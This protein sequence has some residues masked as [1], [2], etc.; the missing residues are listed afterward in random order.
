MKISYQASHRSFYRQTSF[1]LYH[2]HTCQATFFSNRIWFLNPHQQF[3]YK[4]LDLKMAAR[5]SS[6]KTEYGH[7][8]RH[9]V[10]CLS[11]FA[12]PD[13]AEKWDNTGLLVQSMPMDSIMKNVM[14]TNDLTLAVMAEAIKKN[15]DLIIAYHPPIFRPLT[16]ICLDNDWKQSIIIQAIKNKISIYSPHTSLDAVKDG[17]NDWLLVPYGP[18]LTVEAIRKNEVCNN[19]GW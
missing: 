18:F 11:Q 13:L 5:I 9:V 10:Q 16:T 3:L 2:R 6:A 19:N 14:L 4:S 1:R 17:V 15:I 12:P 8:L 7:S